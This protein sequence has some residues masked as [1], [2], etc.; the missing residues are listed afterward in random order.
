[1]NQHV[2]SDTWVINASNTWAPL[3]IVPPTGNGTACA[4]PA[5]YGHC[6]AAGDNYVITVGGSD[7]DGWP[8]DL[9]NPEN[10]EV[11]RPALTAV[12]ALTAPPIR[13]HQVSPLCWPCSTETLGSKAHH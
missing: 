11:Q 6:M 3:A 10:P 12:E 2:L 13:R 8:Y 9:P 4:P 5:R 1:M 7:R